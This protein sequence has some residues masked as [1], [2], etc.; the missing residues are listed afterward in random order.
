MGDRIGINWGWL[1]ATEG[2]TPPADPDDDGRP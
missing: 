1:A 2:L